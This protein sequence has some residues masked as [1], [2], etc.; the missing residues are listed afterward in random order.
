MVRRGSEIVRQLMVYAG[1]ESEASELG[2]LKK[3]EYMLE[4]LSV[5][6]SKHAVL[7][8]DLRR[9][10]FP[11]RASAAQIRQ[12]VVNLVTNAS[13]AIADHAGKIEVT[14]RHSE[15][16][17]ARSRTHNSIRGG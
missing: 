14:T 17:G 3:V 8:T 16:I 1:K 15:N 2:R 13:E 10:L 9:D 12:I 11:V 6:V 7:T 4:L 5:S